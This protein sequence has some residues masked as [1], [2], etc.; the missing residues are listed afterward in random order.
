MHSHP[1][2]AR[3]INADFDTGDTLP[4]KEVIG[5]SD[6][7]HNAFGYS[8]H[9]RKTGTFYAFWR[10]GTEHGVAGAAEIRMRRY[11]SD[12]YEPL[13]SFVTVLTPDP[14]RDL[15]DPSPCVDPETGRLVVAYVDTPTS[16]NGTTYFKSIA[17]DDGGE[18]FSAPNTFAIIPY[19]YAR[20]YGGL[21]I[22]PSTDSAL[23]WEMVTTAYYQTEDTPSRKY[24]VDYFT[25]QDGEYWLNSQDLDEG[26]IAGEDEGAM[27]ETALVGVSPSIWLA[28][29]RGSD[30][31]HLKISKDGR[32]TWTPWEKIWWTDSGKHVAPAA[33]AVK[34]SDG[35]VS[36]FLGATDRSN[37]W[38]EWSATPISRILKHGADAILP[39]IIGPASTNAYPDIVDMGDGNA[40]FSFT[41]EYPGF[42][43]ASYH[44]GF[45][46]YGRFLSRTP[47]F[48]VCLS[49]AQLN[50]ASGYNRVNW[51][52]AAKGWMH[53]ARL[54][55]NTITIT[56]PGRWR[57]TAVVR[58]T[59]GNLD[60]ELQEHAI[61][62]APAGGSF[63]KEIGR[64]DTKAHTYGDDL[65]V[66]GAINCAFGDKIETYV[67]FQSLS[68]KVITPDYVETHF[69][70]EYLGD[71]GS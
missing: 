71:Y 41:R 68:G 50:F 17:S 3:S 66:S 12:C 52:S 61:Y 36:L 44:L 7:R 43:Y 62:R 29:G 58:V 15:R 46:N 32:K 54:D 53:G 63:A 60:K 4:E 13:E 35:Q 22:Q 23:L 45:V 21:K 70:G 64:Y 26:Y 42:S 1:L 67:K 27:S 24:V 25:T 48:K 39:T 38:L 55:G 47:G 16:G 59:A 40:V 57:F 69:I 20:I 2:T 33:A 65:A 31:L 51:S 8:A 37:D 28:I 5:T 14:D 34:T 49:A 6:G 30:D 10:S 56:V 11:A 9:D 18:T 19:A